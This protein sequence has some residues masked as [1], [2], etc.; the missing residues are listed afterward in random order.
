MANT[1][2]FGRRDTAQGRVDPLDSNH[3]EI[4]GLLIDEFTFAGEDTRDVAAAK[5]DR[6]QAIRR[7]PDAPG[8]DPRPILV[9][10]A[11]PYNPEES[12]TAAA[13]HRPPM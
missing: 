10:A 12:Q 3:F 7:T 6:W 8:F 13:P 5:V 1:L 4:D 11:T 2:L 9:P